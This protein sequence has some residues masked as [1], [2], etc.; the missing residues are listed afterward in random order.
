MTNHRLEV[1]RSIHDLDCARR[2]RHVR[3]FQAGR[4]ANPPTA[5]R[6]EIAD[7]IKGCCGHSMLKSLR[8]AYGWGE[9]DAVAAMVA[10]TDDRAGL[11]TRSWFNWEAGSRPGA[12]H[13]DLLCRLFATGPVQLGFATDYSEET[14]DDAGTAHTD[15]PVLDRRMIMAAAHD[16]GDHAARAESAAI[17]E[18]AL[19]QLADDVIALARAYPSTPPF[20]LFEEILRVRNKVYWLLDHTQRPG[21]QH[22]LYLIAGET[23]GLAASA[24]FDLGYPYAAAEQARAAHAYGEIIGHNELRAWSDGMLATIALWSDRPEEALRHIARGL[25]LTPEGTARIRLLCIGARAAAHIDLGQAR[26]ALREA[27]AERDRGPSST[28]IHDTVAG[29]FGFSPARQA[30]CAGSMY[31]QMADYR[32]AQ[33]ECETAVMLYE[34]APPLERWYAAEFSARVDLAASRLMGDDLDSAQS[35]LEAVFALPSGKR[36]EGLVQRMRRLRRTLG[37]K[38][39]AGSSEARTVA[40]RIEEFTATAI[41]RSLPSGR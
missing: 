32:D 5:L 21:Q 13:L 26:T 4:P 36:V 12:R 9:E 39:Y 41:T 2:I 1:T 31:L 24:S 7:E 6:D 34:Q 15:G 11:T 14:T 19:E 16:S 25:A 33:R 30:F 28:E 38:R 35:A 29:E 40:G 10:L 27:V 18:S 22:D 23:C 17:G 3:L 20:P 8:L 37:D